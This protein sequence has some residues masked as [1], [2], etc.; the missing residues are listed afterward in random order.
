MS[1]SLFGAD[2]VFGAE[3]SREAR[4]HLVKP[5][6][7]GQYWAL[8]LGA[9]C[10]PDAGSTTK[11]HPQTLFWY[12]VHNSLLSQ[13]GLELAILLPQPPEERGL[14]SCTTRPGFILQF[15]RQSQ[16]KDSSSRQP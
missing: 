4:L 13:T 2:L 8:D 10:V 11:L 1:G 7:F 3:L 5:K 16:R 6:F 9:L 15:L 14:Q 12:I